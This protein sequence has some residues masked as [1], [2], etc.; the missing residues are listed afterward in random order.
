MVGR[1]HIDGVKDTFEWTLLLMYIWKS[2]VLYVGRSDLLYGKP[3]GEPA[4]QLPI[5][6]LC[7]GSSH[8]DRFVEHTPRR[9]LPCF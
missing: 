6:K 1:P 5:A 2:V 8:W 4:R 9:L 3:V 7:I